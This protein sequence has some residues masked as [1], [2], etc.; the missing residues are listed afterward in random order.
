MERIRLNGIHMV[1]GPAI[2]SRVKFRSPAEQL[3]VDY[4]E[5]SCFKSL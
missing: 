2:L 1:S 3:C 5:A 4:V